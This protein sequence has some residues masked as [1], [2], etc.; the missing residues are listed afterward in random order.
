LLVSTLSKTLGMNILFTL[1]SLL[2]LGFIVIVFGKLKA[3]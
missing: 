2:A 1:I 3:V